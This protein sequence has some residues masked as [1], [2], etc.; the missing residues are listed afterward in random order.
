[1]QQ[2]MVCGWFTR[3]G[4][5]LLLQGFVIAPS[6]N[7]SQR[8]LHE[9]HIAPFRYVICSNDIG[10]IGSRQVTV[11]LDP[12]AFSEENLKKLF[13]LVAKR[14][15]EPSS[16]DVWVKTRLWQIETPEESEIGKISDLGDDPH[17]DQF[18]QALLMRTNGNELFRYSSDE[19][20]PY[21]S[22]KT[23]I[24]KGRDPFDTTRK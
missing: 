5:L 9:T 2:K 8:R 3:I 16:L 17:N 13:Y 10:G 22:L 6:Q 4:L 20:P 11:L 7:A 15:P 12:A 19:K 1:M 23:V 18:Q 21:R 24:L 14:F